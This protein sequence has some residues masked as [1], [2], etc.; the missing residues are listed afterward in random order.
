MN[1]IQQ[2]IAAQRAGNL[3]QAEKLCRQVLAQ[4]QRDFDALH[5]LGIV[6]AQR[7]DYR[8]AERL[9]ARALTVDAR[10]PPCLHNYANVLSKLKRL[11][12]PSATIT[13]CSPSRPVS[14]RSTAI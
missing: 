5:R 6:C 11:R 2:A 8:E 3:V 7:R 10:V 13:R 9:L 12:K 14:R 1:P 4:D